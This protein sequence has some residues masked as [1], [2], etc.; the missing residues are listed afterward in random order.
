MSGSSLDKK[1]SLNLV[2]FLDSKTGVSKISFS[3]KER[4]VSMELLSSWFVEQTLS[5]KNFQK[6]VVPDYDHKNLKDIE[7]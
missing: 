2:S 6:I 1:L 5:L 3:W 7:I 4:T